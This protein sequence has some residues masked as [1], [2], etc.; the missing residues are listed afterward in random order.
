MLEDGS[1]SG[2]VA[3]YRIHAGAAAK[4]CGVEQVCKP[5]KLTEQVH[6]KSDGKSRHSNAPRTPRFFACWTS[7]RLL[8]R[9][10]GAFLAGGASFLA[11]GQP[12][13]IPW[14]AQRQFLLP[15]PISSS[16]LIDLTPPH[17]NNNYGSNDET[18][19]VAARILY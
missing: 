12:I 4:S 6:G 11:A 8:L 5:L 1:G 3:I 10:G 18:W 19:Y 14:A 16:L 17:P 13:R 15:N 7:F 2:K 9:P